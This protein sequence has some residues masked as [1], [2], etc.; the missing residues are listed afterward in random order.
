[1][2]IET[3][4]S[5]AISESLA[6][7]MLGSFIYHDRNVD[8]I[9]EKRMSHV[10]TAKYTI[11][12]LYIQNEKLAFEVKSV[13]HGTSALKG[14]IQSSI[15]KEQVS[16]AIFV[17]QTPR[18]RKL[19]ESIE[20]FSESTGVGVIWINGIP[21]ICSEDMITKATGGCTKPFQLWKE[22]TYSVTRKAIESRSRTEW[23]GDYL[24]ALDR[25]ITDYPDEIF[26]FAVEP[27]P[28]IGGFSDIFV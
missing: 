8:P 23:I 17:M 6:S 20:S 15:Y 27:D 1:M 2:R 4:S 19:K 10:D 3:E 7:Y 22:R 12:D 18:R 13:E 21:S 16:D 26:E 9:F 28:T 25:V 24:D 14:I 11:A 5:I